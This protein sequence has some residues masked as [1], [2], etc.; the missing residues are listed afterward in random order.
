M[1]MK[2]L[3]QNCENLPLTTK[4]EDTVVIV[5]LES[6]KI[7]GQYNPVVHNNQ[8]LPYMMIHATQDQTLSLDDDA[9]H[10]SSNT[11]LR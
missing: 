6:K 8:I 9:C 1:I 3:L 5:G 4:N 10:S 2:I 11:F 7:A